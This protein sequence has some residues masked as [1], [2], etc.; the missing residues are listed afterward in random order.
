MFEMALIFGVGFPILMFIG[1][2]WAGCSVSFSLMLA[3]LTLLVTG[4]CLPI[5]FL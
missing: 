3:M 2:L 5:L 4:G 1:G